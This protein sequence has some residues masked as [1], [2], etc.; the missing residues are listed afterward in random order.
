MSVA[1]C[2]GI[3]EDTGPVPLMAGFFHCVSIRRDIRSRLRIRF[4]SRSK[5]VGVSASL[6]Y[7]THRRKYMFKASIRFP[8]VRL[9]LR[10]LST[11]ALSLNLSIVLG[12]T[13]LRAPLSALNENPRNLHLHGRLTAVSAAL[14]LSSGQSPLSPFRLSSA[15]SC[16]LRS[17]MDV[18]V[19]GV[20]DKLVRSLLQFLVQVV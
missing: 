4:P 14:A 1:R 20:V 2:S 3:P 9:L 10:L 6:K 5:T 19:I 7:A 11:R 12:A 15:L 17:H 8:M 16:S 13:R 18:R